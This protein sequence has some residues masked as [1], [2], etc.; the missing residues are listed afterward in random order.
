MQIT[1]SRLFAA[2]ALCLAPTVIDAAAAAELRTTRDAIR[3]QYIVVLKP[4][5]GTLANERGAAPRVA[6]VAREMSSRHRGQLLRSYSHALRGFAVRADDAALARLLADPRVAYVQEDGVV[7][8]SATQT[9]ATW[10]LDRVDQRALPLNGSYVYD[11]TGAGVRIYVI[12]SG[13]LTTHTEFAGRVGNGASYINDGFGVSDCHGHGTHVAGTAAGTTWGVAKSAI[14][15]PVRVLGCDNSGATSGVIAGIDWVAA[16]RQLPAVANLS[17]GGPG[18]AAL[19]AAVEN[20]INRGV[21]TVI[22]AGNSNAD[23]CGFS[24]AR[25]RRA[26]TIGSIDSNGARSSFSNYGTCLDLF[27]PGGA[28][29]SSWNTG[30]SA[31][32]VLSG[33]S[34]ASPHVAGIAALYLQT[35]PGAGH[36]TVVNEIVGKASVGTVGNPGPASPNHL[37]FSRVSTTPRQ[38]FFRYFSSVTG[39]HFYTLNWNE[40][41]GGGFGGWTYESVMGWMRAGSAAGTVPIYRYRN[42]FSG[43]YFYT[44]NFAE[45]G[46]GSGPWVYEGPAG[47][48]PTLPAGDTGSLYRYYNNN[49]GAHFY[50]SSFS[51]LG[52]GGSGGWV[53]EGVIAPIWNQP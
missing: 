12:D 11:H 23:A 3:G 32:A 15:H 41:G 27:A 39:S 45:L 51:E 17:L 35:N 52:G 36:A 20:L 28:I 50:T 48:A 47:Y 9:G 43:R 21:T 53:Y 8:G 18:N 25:V 30:N 31:T 49:S 34:M 38:A 22:A 40:L 37:A 7:R 44:A 46:G 24:P 26:L 42:N 4:E 6:E 1:H 2:L 16:N 33:T 13:L 5:A 29:T 19:D 14:V 10:G